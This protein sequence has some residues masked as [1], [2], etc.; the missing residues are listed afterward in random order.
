[1]AGTR[2]RTSTDVS[3]RT[4]G[5]LLLRPGHLTAEYFAGRRQRYPPPVRLY[6][7]LLSVLFFSLAGPVAANRRAVR[8]DAATG[9]RVEV[10]VGR[11]E[12]RLGIGGR[13]RCS[14]VASG[15]C[16]AI[17]ARCLRRCATTSR[18]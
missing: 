2:S 1:M 8:R 18:G 14:A 12:L 9:R 3:G 15:S 16:R 7:V 10:E 6:L 4:F 17:R 11:C 5:A 13:W